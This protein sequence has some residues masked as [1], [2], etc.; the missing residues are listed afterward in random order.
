MARSTATITTN[1][2]LDSQEVFHLIELHFE[3]STWSDIFV[4]DNTHSIDLQTPTQTAVKSYTALGDLLGFTTVEETT[5]LAINSIQLSLSGID[6]TSTGIIA[7]L[8]QAPIINKRVVIYRSFGVANDTDTTKTYM[9]FDG[10]VKSWD[11]SEGKESSIITLSISSHWA[12]FEQRNGRLTNST[13]QSNTKRYGS[14]AT[15]DSDRGLEY[16]SAAIADIQ[17]GPS[18]K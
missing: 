9:I 8:F 16:A 18:N 17:W 6:N 5:A 4:T 7:K 15:F 11:I 3:D 1:L 13:T 12:N 10:N 2:Q 14:T